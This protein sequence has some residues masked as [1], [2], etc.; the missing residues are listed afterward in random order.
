MQMR[1]PNGF[2]RTA[3]PARFTAWIPRSWWYVQDDVHK[4][5][6]GHAHSLAESIRTLPSNASAHGQVRRSSRRNA[7]NGNTETAICGSESN[8]VQEAI[9]D[10]IPPTTCHH[11][12][13]ESL[14]LLAQLPRGR[15][16]GINAPG[17]S[18]R[19]GVRSIRHSKGEF[20]LPTLHYSDDR[21]WVSGN[22]GVSEWL[23]TGTTPD[24]VR[25]EVRGCDHWEFRD[26]KVIKK[27]SY[28]K[29]VDQ[30]R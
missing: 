13:S 30:S 12:L 10:A 19:A 7:N 6:H 28:W 14:M 17:Q 26:G 27:N 25:I 2:F 16:T 1:S 9:A 21:H 3:S 11:G 4:L 18:G 23:L 22:M 5:H 24:G 20:P 8:I 29:I 15:N